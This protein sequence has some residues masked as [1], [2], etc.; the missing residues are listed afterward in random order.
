MAAAGQFD[1]AVQ[2]AQAAIDMANSAG[3]R[4]LAEQIRQRL[5]GYQQQRPFRDKTDGS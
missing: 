5:E 4:Q 1:Q 2:W 3:D